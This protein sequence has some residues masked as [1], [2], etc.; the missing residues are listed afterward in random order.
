MHIIQIASRFLILPL[1]LA[2][3]AAGSAAAAEVEMQFYGNQ[4][5][6][7]KSPGGKVILINPWITGNKDVPFGIEHY[8]KGEVDLI[9]VTAGHGDDVGQAVDIAANTGAAV[10]APAELGGWMAGQIAEL[11]GSKS[12]V[13]GGAISGR[14][15]L[16]DITVQMLQAL[17]GTGISAAGGRYGGFA[18]GFLITFENGLKVL[19]AGSTGLTLDL[20][21]FGM[22]YQPHVVMVP[23]AGRYM[24]HPD[25][26][27]FATKLLM[28]DNPNLKTA[29]PQHF[30]IAG[31]PD[32]MG[33]PDEYEAEVRKLGL[34]VNVLKPEIGKT[35]TL[36]K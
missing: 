12:Q 7:F 5:F 8:K 28:T 34:D 19:M 31:K 22:R 10:F 18:A 25:D 29:I 9:L 4:H 33:T 2:A 36:T 30:R 15:H 14:Y 6:L 16:G 21:L 35:Y 1:M 13:Y 3:I 20:Q 17:H 11:G 27:A 24:M 23:I 26:A 32:W